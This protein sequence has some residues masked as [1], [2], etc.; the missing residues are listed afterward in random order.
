M[1]PNLDRPHEF[2][3]SYRLVQNPDDENN[4]LVLAGTWDGEDMKLYTYTADTTIPTVISLDFSASL[5]RISQGVTYLSSPSYIK[6]LWRN[7]GI[8][9]M[10]EYLKKHPVIIVPGILGS[11]YWPFT[12]KWELDPLKHTY[13]YLYNSFIAAGFTPEV[14]LFKFPY[15]WRSDNRETAYLLKEKIDEVKAKSGANKVD[16]VAH[17]MGGIVTRIYAQSDAYQ[18]DINQ[19]VFV[20]TPQDGSTS[21]YPMWEAGD[22]SLIDSALRVPLYILLKEE[23]LQSGYIVDGILKYI[24]N[25][26]PS[27]S[28]LLP[29]YSYLDGSIYPEN[30]PRNELLETLNS[31]ESVIQ[32]RGIKVTN[33]VGSG[34]ETPS[35]LNVFNGE[36]GIYWPHGKPS[37]YYYSDG[38]GTVLLSSQLGVSG[39]TVIKNGIRHINLPS[40]AMNEIMKALGI[41]YSDTEVINIINKYLFIAA[42][43]P[44]DFYVLAPD[45][46]RIGFNKDGAEFNEIEGAFYTG[47]ASETEFLTIPNPLPGEY[48]VVT[49]GTGTGSYEIEATYADDEKDTAITSSYTGETVLEKETNILVELSSD[50]SAIEAKVDDKV[51][52]V[53]T[54]SV[55]STEINGYYNADTKVILSATDDESGVK[56]T[57]YSLDGVIWQDYSDPIVLDNDGEITLSYR[58]VDKSDNVESTQTLIVRIDKTTPVISLSLNK[59]RFTHWD[60]LK[61]SCKASDSYSGINE[62]VVSMDGETIDCSKSVNLF[63]KNIGSHKIEYRATDMAGNI[64]IGEKTYQLIV[65]YESTSRDIIWLYE[66]KHFKSTSDA[67]NVLAS[68]D[69]S[70]LLDILGMKKKAIDSLNQTQSLLDKLV[71]KKKIST[72]GYDM[73]TRDIKYLLE[74]K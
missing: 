49:Y 9:V 31:G 10:P 61:L 41:K 7:D 70:Y 8:A 6:G 38:D 34:V 46:K 68:V 36:F 58:S 25:N 67:I 13:D 60:T 63:D 73:I 26:V 21:S 39:N 69:I 43:S 2:Q 54:A 22:M 29:V 74:G 72:Y 3:H 19:I 32:Q 57:E 62:F 56:K 51:A 35:D 65:N 30:Y 5:M 45:G 33:I 50:G 23:S 66:N 11:W 48:K 18:S 53:T 40:Q 1:S 17:S 16:I 12:N 37:S 55:E 44:V 24:R 4:I 14:E 42:Y 52:P 59:T 71:L 47:N 28:Q 15:Q 64:M 20:G 27:I